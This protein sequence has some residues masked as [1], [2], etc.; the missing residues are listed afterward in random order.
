MSEKLAS[1]IAEI[2]ERIFR[3]QRRETSINEEDTKRVFITPLLQAL[4]WD[5][6]DLEEVKNEYRHRPQYNPVDYALFLLRTPCLYIEAKPLRA[7]LSD[8]KWISQTIGYAASAGVE[9]CILTNGDEYRLYN[10]H[11]PVEAEQKLFRSVKLSGDLAV[12]ADTLALLTKDKMAEKRL[13]VLWKAH[14]VDRRVKSSVLELVNS[15]DGS[16]IRLIHRKTSGLT[17]GDIRN[18]LKRADLQIDFPESAQIDVLPIESSTVSPERIPSETPLAKSRKRQYRCTL[19]DLIKAGLLVPPVTLHTKFKKQPFSS[20]IQ[21]D[22]SVEFQGEPYKSLSIAAAMARNVAN[23]P[24]P[25]GRKYWQ[26]NGW[27]FWKIRDERT[28]K[29]A[30]IDKVRQ[31]YLR[32]RDA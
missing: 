16:F 3:A 20:T 8:H 4:G 1:E 9:W 31:D 22:G 25:D 27:T 19:S 12:A 11:A 14:F 21:S 18:S 23:G 6:Q 26:T 5:I 13:N 17:Q 28:G 15:Q 29:E 24:P 32:V 10:A 2:R 30:P 7:S